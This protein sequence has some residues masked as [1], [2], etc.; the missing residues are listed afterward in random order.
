MSDKLSRF[1]QAEIDQINTH[2]PAKPVPLSLILKMKEPGYRLRDG[3]FSNF[4]D[5]EIELIKELIPEKYWRQ[6]LL[7]IIIIR[8]RDLGQSAYTVGG[9]DPNRYIIESIF[10]EL[11]SF[12]L[13]RL[14]KEETRIFYK[15]HIRQ[16]RKKYKS[17]TVIGFT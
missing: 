14:E 13:W 10:D 7:P 16:I 11:P 6:V 12:E 1:L 9:S 5:D 2:L 4:N 8:R 17:T 3:Q 15:P